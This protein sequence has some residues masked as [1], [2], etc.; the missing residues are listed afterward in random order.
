MLQPAVLIGQLPVGPVCARRAGL[1]QLARKRVGL[2][3]LSSSSQAVR[4]PAPQNLDLFDEV[5][6]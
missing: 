4:V 6:A 3:K 2:L 1:V 5:P